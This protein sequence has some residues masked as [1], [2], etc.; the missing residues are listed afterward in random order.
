MSRHPQKTI[1]KTPN[2]RLPFRHEFCLLDQ[3][4]V[5]RSNISKRFKYYDSPRLFGGQKNGKA[6]DLVNRSQRERRE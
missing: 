1:G 6:V 4:G 5:E 3:T 2:S